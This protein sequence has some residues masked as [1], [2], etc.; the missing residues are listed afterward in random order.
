MPEP[1]ICDE[2][3]DFEFYTQDH[4]ERSG[5]PIRRGTM[6]YSFTFTL[7][8][9]RLLRL[10]CGTQT[11]DAFQR[12]CI[13]EEADDATERL[14]GGLPAGLNPAALECPECQGKTPRG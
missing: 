5:E 1:C 4:P 6:A 3:A 8:D 10:H 2:P 11:R 14:L 12:F 7:D 9:G 13:Q